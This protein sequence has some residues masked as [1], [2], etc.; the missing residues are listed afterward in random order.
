MFF[1]MMID[2]EDRSILIVGGGQVAY[3]KAKA[4]LEFG[5][6]ITLV[7]PEF[8]E[9]FIALKEKSK[10]DN[11]IELIYDVYDASYVINKFLVVAATSSRRVN[12]EVVRDCNIHQI[13]V[14]NVDGREKSD[15]ITPA[16]YKNDDLT[17][18]ISTGGSFPYLSKRMRMD[19]EEK[20]S[21]YNAE[22]MKLLESIRYKIIDKYPDKKR[23]IMD[24]VLKLDI[25]E[26]KS[27]K[28][29][30]DDKDQGDVI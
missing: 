22:Y 18:S 16:I 5:A 6:S 11:E 25:D 4:M 1:P 10:S 7:S 27:F 12:K 21:K 14:N 2:L 24:K 29:E 19:M 13:L 3:R 17:I 28:A 30:I 8:T 20:Y 9:E 15:F 23:Q 26:L